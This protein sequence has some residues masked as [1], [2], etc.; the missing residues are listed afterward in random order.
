MCAKKIDSAIVAV[1][2]LRNYA[3]SILINI[4]GFTIFI[5]ATKPINDSTDSCYGYGA[6]VVLLIFLFLFILG[7]LNALLALLTYLL[8]INKLFL[9]N[10]KYTII[11]ICIFYG[12]FI[13]WCY[14]FLDGSIWG[15]F[16]SWILSCVTTI[17]T[18]FIMSRTRKFRKLRKNKKGR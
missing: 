6:G 15:L 1:C 14:L 3:L 10:Y 7:P 5:W 17:I 2:V 9:L 11:E 16:T 12:S 8:K 4:V 18:G 13:G